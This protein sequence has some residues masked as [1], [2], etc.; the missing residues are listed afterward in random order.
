VVEAGARVI[1]DITAT[2]IVVTGTVEGSLVAKERIQIGDGADLQGGA[3]AP[4]V[5]VTDGAVV[6]GR[7]ETAAPANLRELKAAS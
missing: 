2:G 1:G 7:I 3:A 4:R 5:I 6:N